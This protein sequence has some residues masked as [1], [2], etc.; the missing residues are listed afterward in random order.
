MGAMMDQTTHN[1]PQMTR[2]RRGSRR[3]PSPRRGST[4]NRAS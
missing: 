3:R 1:V 4:G 2:S